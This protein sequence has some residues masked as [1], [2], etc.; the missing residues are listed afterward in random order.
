MSPVAR[1]GDPQ[2]SWDAARS[3]T[4]ITELQGRILAALQRHRHDPVRQPGL[5]HGELVDCLREVDP[6][7]TLS[8]SRT[9]CAELVALGLV[10]DSGFVRRTETG[11]RAIVWAV[12]PGN[13]P[14]ASEPT[15]VVPE[16]PDP[17]P[18][19]PDPAMGSRGERRS[20]RPGRPDRYIDLDRVER[21]ADNDARK[22]RES[23]DK[24]VLKATPRITRLTLAFGQRVCPRCGGNGGN[25]LEAC[26][27]CLGQ[28]FIP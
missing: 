14:S 19:R 25:L 3:V 24:G 27:R 13:G 18:V 1:R 7:V 21:E 8:G 28:G 4:G 17:V 2:T 22:S 9:R 10:V 11:R 23:Y 16:S 6:T 15:P 12:A 26:T 20:E 5:T